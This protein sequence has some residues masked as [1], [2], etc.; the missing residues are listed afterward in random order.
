MPADTDIFSGNMA[1]AF[2]RPQSDVM[3]ACRSAI[4]RD[5]ISCAGLSGQFPEVVGCHIPQ[6]LAA[7]NRSCD[8]PLQ[9]NDFGITA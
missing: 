8:T 4:S 2:P 1:W 6:E 9:C 5:C 7:T 3:T